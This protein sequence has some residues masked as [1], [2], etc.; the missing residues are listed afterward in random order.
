MVRISSITPV[1]TQMSFVCSNCQAIQTIN[2]LDGKYRVPT[3]CVSAGC[4]S[5]SFIPERG[6]QR[7]DTSTI[8]MQK[9]RIQE[10]LSD[11]QFDSERIPRIIECEVVQDLIDY[12]IPGD[13]VKITGVVKVHSTNEGGG[14]YN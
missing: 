11:D 12:V 13:I 2:F 9:I 8:D 6:V 14:K 10:S 7:G 1:V 5:K 4:K 3:K